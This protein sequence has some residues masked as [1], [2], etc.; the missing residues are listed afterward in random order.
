MNEEPSANAESLGR[1]YEDYAQ[2]IHDFLLRT[3]RNAAVAEDL[4]QTTFV[5]A[6][7]K[8]DTVRDKA[9]VKSWL[10][11][12]AH[13]LAM[14][15]V[16]RTKPAQDI[17]DQADLAAV[18][19]GPEEKA[20]SSEAAQLVWD[21][22][23]SLEPRQY[24]VLDLTVRQGLTT[25]EVAAALEVEPGHAA[26]LV[27]RSKEALGNAVRFLLVARRR[28]HCAVLADLIPEG[29]TR[30]TAKQRTSVDHHMRRCDGCRQMGIS[31]TRPAEILSLLPLVQLP[32][33]ALVIPAVHRTHAAGT[34]LKSAAKAGKLSL[35]KMVAL[36]VIGAAVIGGGAVALGHARPAGRPA[37]AADS[38]G[39]G[40]SRVVGTSRPGAKAP[41]A[42]PVGSAADFLALT[43]GFK[44]SLNNADNVVGT[45]L[46]SPQAVTAA[47]VS[48]V[49]ADSAVIRD[50]A[51]GLRQRDWGPANADAQRLAADCDRIAGLFDAFTGSP[52]SFDLNSI[53]PV[54]NAIQADGLQL[55]RDLGIQGDPTGLFT[56]Q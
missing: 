49:R 44:T 28:T 8:S 27:N 6:F 4:T 32:K 51:G 50:Y 36:G 41:T 31:L 5:K 37:A 54:G 19:P 18:A 20:V 12:I 15:T 24:A 45:A 42:T 13:N 39:G 25:P 21:A 55:E 38:A 56:G 53:T 43:D 14:D 47:M 7:E 23:A 22:A 10:F 40:H 17:D 34:A 33:S 2:A 30:L 3:V 16:T 48:A 9:R 52:Q 46:T 29:V 11:S 1:L 35:G 26:V